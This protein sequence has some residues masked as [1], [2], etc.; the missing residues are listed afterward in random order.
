MVCICVCAC[1]HGCWHI[2]VLI[3]T[4]FASGIF[5]YYST[6]LT[7]A[8]SPLNQKSV[9][10]APLVGQPALPQT[11]E[12]WDS[13]RPAPPIKPFTWLLGLK[14]GSQRW[15][16]IPQLWSCWKSSHWTQTTQ[17]NSTT[18][19]WAFNVNA[20]AF[21][22]SHLKWLVKV[23]P[24]FEG[25]WGS[26]WSHSGFNVHVCIFPSHLVAWNGGKDC[27]PRVDSEQE[28]EMGT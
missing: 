3:E 23:A 9:D 8:I 18:S 26:L 4:R 12:C 2:H 13:R 11:S 19:C 25:F 17:S 27:W 28:G 10:A 22:A 16:S 7:E 6:L 21:S 5:L 14:S 20:L 1:S 24:G 15:L